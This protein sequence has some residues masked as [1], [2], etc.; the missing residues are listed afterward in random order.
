MV[1]AAEV[2]ACAAPSV[3]VA[4]AAAVVAAAALAA[5]VAPAACDVEAASLL[6]TDS[7]DVCAGETSKYM[8]PVP[9]S[10]RAARTRPELS[11]VTKS[12][13]M[14]CVHTSHAANSQALQRH[15]GPQ[16]ATLT[17]LMAGA[18]RRSLPLVS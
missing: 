3:A 12:L 11:R 10:N 6:A 14:T 9:C 4:A 13:Y 5:A 2:D 1:V 17:V 8:R 18:T 7:P 15:T 16:P